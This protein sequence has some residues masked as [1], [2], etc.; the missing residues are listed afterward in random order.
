MGRLHSPSLLL[1]LILA[2]GVILVLLSLALTPPWQVPDEPQHFQLARL[3]ADLR[4]WPTLADVANAQALHDEVYGSMVRHRFWEIRGHRLPPPS[5]REDTA[6]D[7]LLP[8]VY[9]PPAYYAV[10]ASVLAPLADTPVDAQLYAMR[11]L[12]VLLGT[13][14]VL[15]VYVFSRRVF[16]SEAP[17]AL[18]ATA[19]AALLPMRTALAGGASSDTLASLVGAA[20]ILVMAVW[21]R[22][23][24][25][26]ARGAMLGLL[27]ALALLT[28]R[29]TAFLAPL[30][31]VFLLLNRRA[32]SHAARGHRAWWL[33]V[34]AAALCLTLPL[35]AWTLARPPLAET[36]QPWPYPGYTPE[37][38]LGVRLEWLSRLLGSEAWTLAALRGY[39]LSLGVSFASFWADFG[40]LTVPLDVGWYVALAGLALLAVA[41]IV[42][43]LR[44][45]A[46]CTELALALW[47]AGLAVLQLVGT[48]WGQNVPQQGRYLFPALGPIAC[49]FVLGW[50][51]WLPSRARQWM[52]LGVGGGL[53]LLT[54][55]SWLGYA[56]PAFYG[57]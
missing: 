46:V 10:A 22:D 26:P 33:A 8:P 39:A 51:E 9:A 7:L 44:R 28:K 14:E 42:R 17:L 48:T 16:P 30:A 40:W 35:L 21:V 29:T 52:P 38:L 45:G 19:F 31:V 54:A 1:A 20:A 34:G 56:L 55:V 13:L 24:L 57:G 3:L 41:G 15:L 32:S 27:V 53:L 25:T 18:A 37:G 49:A 4:R 50:S 12:S 11:L 36:G 47:A 43:R 6:P 2:L 23:P 5:L